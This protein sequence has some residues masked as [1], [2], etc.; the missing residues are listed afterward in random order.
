MRMMVGICA[1]LASTGCVGELLPDAQPL[2]PA[3]SLGSLGGLDQM[4]WSQMDMDLGGMVC[5][6]SLQGQVQCRAGELFDL[7]TGSD[8]V[9]VALSGHQSGCA[10][11]SAGEV[12]CFGPQMDSVDVPTGP[13]TQVK[14]LRLSSW[15]HVCGLRSSGQ[16]EC[17]GE[18]LESPPQDTS[19]VDFSGGGRDWCGVRDDGEVLCW[20]VDS[21]FET[22]ITR[23]VPAGT[24]DAVEVGEG[25]ACA[26]AEGEVSCWGQWGPVDDPP[27]VPL[28]SMGAGTTVL[29]GTKLDGT[30]QCWG[31]EGWNI[32]DGVPTG[33][34]SQAIPTLFE[35]CGLR[36]SGEVLCWGFGV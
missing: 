33:E 34:L 4:R 25:F 31:E 10:L 27:D 15:S 20:R 19:F 13:F 28:Q 11:D 5:G 17:W 3:T 14:G 1:L 26:S 18:D 12:T 35:A 29:C 2:T 21:D 16:L 8:F 30:G 36:P 7:P 23:E 9:Q 6:V 22:N 32:R 24:F